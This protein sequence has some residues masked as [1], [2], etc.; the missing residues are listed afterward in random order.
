ML[1]KHQAAAVR[2]LNTPLLVLSGAG[3]G[4]TRVI[5]EKMLHIVNSHFC[6]PD[7]LYAIT[8]TNKAAKEMQQRLA[9]RYVQADLINISTFHALGLRLLKSEVKHT[10]L[11]PGFS[12]LDPSECTQ[13][14]QELVPKGLKKNVVYDIQWQI[15]DWKNAGL[16]P[17]DATSNNPLNQDIYRRYLEYMQ[18]INAVDFDDLIAMSLWLLQGNETVRKR[19]QNQ[20]S[21]LLVDEYQDTN[22]CQYQLIKQLTANNQGLTCVGDDDQSIYGWRGARPENLQLLANDFPTLEVVK[23]EQNY[24]STSTILKA[25]D[26]VVQ[27]NPHP[28]KKTIWSDLGEGDLIDLS[29]HDSIEEEAEHIATA[30]HF[31]IQHNHHQAGDYGILY[32]SNRQA[33]TIEQALRRFNIPYHISG[34][35]SFFDYTEIKDLMA[36]LRLL[37]NP[38]DNAAFL[39]VINTPR[40]GIGM[41]TVKHI[42]HSAKLSNRSFFHFI[43]QAKLD[44]HFEPR[45]AAK[46]HDFQRMIANFCQ[47]KLTA[48]V[49]L[50]QLLNQTDYLNWVEHNT[51]N[52]VAKVNKRKLITDFVRWVN[53]ICKNKPT[54]LEELVSYLTLQTDSNDDDT[55]GVALMTLHAAKG[56]EFNQVFLIG[57]EEGLLPHSSSLEEAEDQSEALAEERRLMY[58]GMT[59]A[60]NKL[61]ISY[62]KKRKSKHPTQQQTSTGPSRFID[63]IPAEFMMAPDN[64]AHKAKT[65]QNF[66]ALKAQLNQ[67]P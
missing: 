25:A 4:K 9:K 41:Q 1:N 47:S 54:D 40:R 55:Q 6:Q 57:I 62:V 53:A 3:C 32:R 7:H 24:R 36:Y 59:R 27:H 56:L 21:Y 48:D 19:W 17:A 45:M 65:K 28:F 35:R 5:V 12:I 10:G 2:H 33:R 22:A 30:I 42:A 46:L 64:P 13:I 37:T 11:L 50:S 26:A 20:V 60:Q 8:F 29:S 14:I 58:V 49:I 63:E 66:A 15:S 31:S 38:F 43:S 16:K 23:L 51:A 18:S 52:Q 61:T 67:N 44:E 34:G 39:R